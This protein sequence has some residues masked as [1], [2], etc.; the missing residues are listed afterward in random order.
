MTLRLE[1]FGHLDCSPPLQVEEIRRVAGTRTPVEPAWRLD[2]L[3]D[4]HPEIND[5][6]YDGQEGLYL[7]PCPLRGG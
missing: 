2:R 1:R 4:G 5:V 6:R 3:L 7:P